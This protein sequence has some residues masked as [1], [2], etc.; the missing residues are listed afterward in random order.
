VTDIHLQHDYPEERRRHWPTMRDDPEFWLELK[1]HMAREEDRLK[2]G[3]T[4]MDRIE[5]DLRPI[6]KMYYALIGSSAIGGFLLMTLLYI[7][8]QDKGDLKDMQ[9]ILYRQGTAIEKLL[10]AHV[11]LE[12][13]FRR[14]FDRIERERK[15]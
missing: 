9:Q 1:N 11:E 6:K 10:Q 14:E 4:R 13:D 7:Y 12:K 15:R 3:E 5:E 8:S 2:E